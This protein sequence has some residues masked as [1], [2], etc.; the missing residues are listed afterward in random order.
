[1]ETKMSTHRNVAPVFNRY[2]NVFDPINNRHFFK[3]MMKHRAYFNMFPC[4][5]QRHQIC[6]KIGAKNLLDVGCGPG[7]QDV[8]LAKALNMKVTGIDVAANMIQ[9]AEK[10]SELTEVKQLCD[11]KV[12]DFMM[13]QSDNKFDVVSSF[14]VIEYVKDTEQFLKNLMSYSNKIVIFTFPVK[15]HWFMP[16]RFLYYK[17]RHCPLKINTYTNMCT[18]I[19]QIGVKNYNIYRLNRNYLVTIRVNN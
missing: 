13:F 5:E 16:L 6:H 8:I 1:M 15:W 14:G 17:F 12:A 3:R 7:Y 2:A 11:F 4:F 9:I 10:N 19:E 18:C